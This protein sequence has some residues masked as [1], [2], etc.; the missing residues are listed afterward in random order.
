MQAHAFP[1]ALV[2]NADFQ[3]LN[4]FPL[5]ILGWQDV[6]AAVV[7]DTVS[8]VSEYDIVVRSPSTE[9][10][11]PSVVALKEYVPAPKR[12]AFTRFNVFL[13]DRFRCQYCSHSF[14]SS[15]LTFD[16][17]IPRSK[18]GTTRWEN[19]VAACSPCN[20]RKDK[21]LLKPLRWPREPTV[22][23]MGAAKRAFPPNYLHETWMDWL[24]WSQELEE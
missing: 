2:L 18:G 22:H 1:P 9:I 7:K 21:Y 3:P 4:Q 10:R 19:I 24:Y 23:E 14:P 12:V 5:S 8:V 17:V 15:D 20:T 11:L 13:R 16:H 6:V